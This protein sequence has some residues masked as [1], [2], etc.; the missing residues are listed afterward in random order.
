M[1]FVDSEYSINVQD[2]R[3]YS[4]NVDEDVKKDE[5]DSSDES[6]GDSLASLPENEYVVAV[7]EKKKKKKYFLCIRILMIQNGCGT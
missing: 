5:L 1:E 6:T 7:R 2:D 4:K 3:Q